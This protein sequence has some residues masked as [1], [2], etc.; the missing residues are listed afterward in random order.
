M[1]ALL[2]LCLTLETCTA[3]AKVT[4]VDLDIPPPRMSVHQKWLM[5][6]E[7]KTS[8]WYLLL[9]YLGYNNVSTTE[10]GFHKSSVILFGHI[11]YANPPIPRWGNTFA[12]FLVASHLVWLTKVCHVSRHN[13]HLIP[14]PVHILDIRIYIVNDICVI[15]LSHTHILSLL[16]ACIH[17]HNDTHP[18]SHRFP[19][20]IIILLLCRRLVISIPLALR[21][22]A[23]WVMVEMSLLGLLEM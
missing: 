2:W 14:H 22:M 1:R 12:P 13:A 18:L 19:V 15:Y 20:V 5:L 4:K 23:S 7:G 9:S 6:L 10:E 16:Y 8:R 21:R 3:G 17:M 11:H